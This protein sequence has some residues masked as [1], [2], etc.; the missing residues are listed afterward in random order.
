MVQKSWAVILQGGQVVSWWTPSPCHR[1]SL[2]SQLMT[3][4]PC[5]SFLYKECFHLKVSTPF[6]SFI[7]LFINC[8]C[9]GHAKPLS[10]SVDRQM[11]GQTDWFC[12]PHLRYSRQKVSFCWDCNLF[13]NC[14]VVVWW[15]KWLC[16]LNKQELETLLLIRVSIFSMKMLFNTEAWGQNLSHLRS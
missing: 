1:E 11:G 3:F 10:V 15:F 8:E 4:G 7:P 12:Y 6:N 9:N 14:S 5:T 2:K 13:P 16:V